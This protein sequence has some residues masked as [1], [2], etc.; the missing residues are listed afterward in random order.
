MA[1]GISSLGGINETDSSVTSLL[2]S[3]LKDAATKAESERA[4]QLRSSP[5]DKDGFLKLLVAQLQNQDP[6]QPMDNQQFT[7]QLSQFASVEQ[8]QNM[9]SNLQKSG[10]VQQIAQIQGLIGQEVSYLKSNPTEPEAEGTRQRGVVDAIR[11][12]QDKTL[13]MI[14]GEEVD[15]TQIDTILRQNFDKPDSLTTN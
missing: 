11:I 3:D 8:L 10:H 13:A 14:G 2:G 6:T 15:V 9:N 12:L 1:L 5:I 7:Q 4:T